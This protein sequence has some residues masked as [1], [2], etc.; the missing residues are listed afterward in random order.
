MSASTNL[1]DHLADH[2]EVG[3]DDT[4]DAFSLNTL[5]TDTTSLSPSV[6]EYV[7]ENGRRYKSDRATKGDYMLPNDETEQERLDLTH[8]MYNIMLKGELFLAPLVNPK[9]V[10]DLGT[11]TGMCYRPPNSKIR[12]NGL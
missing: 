3:D 4:S 6:F 11:G 10:L 2:I 9:R 8:H 1:E 5:G 12:G 7:Y